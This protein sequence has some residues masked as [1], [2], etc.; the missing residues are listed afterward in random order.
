MGK[1]VIFKKVL[2]M[3]E[4]LPQ[5]S[6]IQQLTS[7]L[8]E[9]D[10]RQYLKEMIPHNYY[11][12][13]AY[14]DEKVIAV[15]GYWIGTKIYCGKYL[16][17]DNFVVDEAFRNSGIGNEMIEWLEIEARNEHCKALMLDAYVENFKA[18]AFYYRTGFVA[19]GFHYIKHLV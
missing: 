14:S 16:E 3:S 15:C 5:L 18:H 9:T 2:T 8:T 4:M 12:L 10:Y 7:K 11:Q 13:L 6:L 19:R 1:P 17:L